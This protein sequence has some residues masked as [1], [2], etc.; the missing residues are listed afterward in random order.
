MITYHRL[1]VIDINISLMYYE[2]PL[3]IVKVKYVN[4]I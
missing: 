4:L 3:N 2:D 1:E